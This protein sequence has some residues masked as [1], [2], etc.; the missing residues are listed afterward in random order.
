MIFISA[1]DAAIGRC[2]SAWIHAGPGREAA[3]L[4]ALA[5]IFVDGGADEDAKRTAGFDEFRTRLAHLDLRPLLHACGLS[6]EK[7]RKLAHG[8]DKRR[9]AAFLFGSSSVRGRQGIAFMTA[10]W[11]LALLLRGTAVPLVAGANE[12]GLMA[13]NKAFIASTRGPGEIEAWI[14]TTASPSFPKSGI[15]FLVA[16]DAFS[17]SATAAAD[18]VLPQAVFLETGGT[19]VNAEGGILRISAASDP[20]GESR[21]AWRIFSELAARLGLSGVGGPSAA[22]VSLRLDESIPL[23][24]PSA[25][26][27]D[28]RSENFMV[29]KS[30]GQERFLLL[31]GETEIGAGLFPAEPPRAPRTDIYKGLDLAAEV[32]GLR[33]IREKKWPRS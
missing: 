26:G 9:P 8:L 29:E 4:L 22:A 32:K 6:E 12:L 3:F 16:I 5:K 2:A 14:G 31:D 1:E 17:S 23:L 11:N 19:L 10:L 21:P 18:V 24:A 20:A 28:S 27:S 15:R 25:S 30:G 7:A 13:L 33:S